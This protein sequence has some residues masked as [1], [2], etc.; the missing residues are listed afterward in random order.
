MPI[1]PRNHIPTIRGETRWRVVTEPVF[2]VTV[3]RDAIVIP[4]GDELGGF[5]CA[6]QCAGFV[7][8]ALHHATI[9]HEYIGEVV[10]DVQTVFIELLCQ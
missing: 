8:D 5:E 4:K 9:A 7:A 1:D 6:R 2:N 10:N 3:N